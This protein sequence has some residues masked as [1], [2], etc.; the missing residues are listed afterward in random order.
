M[1]RLENIKKR[2]RGKQVLADINL[3]VEKGEIFALLGPNGA[4]KTTTLRIIGGQLNPT[5]GEVEV[6]GTKD[7]EGI[8]DKISILNEERTLFPRL[9]VEDYRTIYKLLY[10]HFDEK[11]FNE[12]I[13]HYSIALSERADKLSAGTKTMLFLALCM[14]SGASIL[15]L[16]EPTHNLDPVKKDEVLRLIRNFAQTKETTIVISSHEIYELEEII[17]SFAIIR[18][19]KILYQ[20]TIDNAKESHRIIEE[21]ESIPEGE[22]IGHLDNKTLIKTQKNIG[23]YPNFKE[24]VVGYLKKDME[25]SIFD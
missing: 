24:L 20:D 12:I 22:I 3:K 18:E 14:A 11:L 15:L 5:S 2:F 10:P 6:L 23:R 17:T 19:G 8:K 9:K 1:I 13:L 16:D 7:I 4:G 25:I 21:G